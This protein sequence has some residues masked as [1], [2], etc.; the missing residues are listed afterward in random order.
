MIIYETKNQ[1]CASLIASMGLMFDGNGLI[2][3]LYSCLEA[4]FNREERKSAKNVISGKIGEKIVLQ[5][6]KLF[7]A[8]FASFAANKKADINTGFLK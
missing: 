3:R 1:N 8:L 5:T 7:F 4:N 2:K 6:K